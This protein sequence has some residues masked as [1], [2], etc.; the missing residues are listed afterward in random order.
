MQIINQYSAIWIAVFLVVTMAAI[1]LRRKPKWPHFLVLAV[2]VLGLA[3][4]WIFLHP[5]QTAQI[6]T[7]AQ[8]QASIGR[9]T[10]VLLELQSPYWIAC[11]AMKPIVDGIEKQYQGRLTVI[12]V[13]I[14]SETGRALAPIYR[15]QYTP[16]FIFF[17]G[18]GK[19]LWRSIGQ[20]DTGKV[21][22]SLK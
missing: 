1:L 19:E 7:A 2:V 16:T 11:T 17:D 6:S 15:F 3:T 10:P 20:L 22:E 21:G 5:R 12:R 8:V 13:D 9:G 18:Q 4:A 14:Q